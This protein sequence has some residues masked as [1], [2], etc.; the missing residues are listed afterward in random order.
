MS[1]G[2]DGGQWRPPMPIV[3]PR[4]SRR[5]R[6]AAW[7]APRVTWLSVVVSLVWCL[8]VAVALSSALESLRTDDFD[9]LNNMF[10]LPFAFPWALL[11][12]GGFWSNEADSWLLAALG[13]LNGLAILI[14]LDGWIARLRHRQR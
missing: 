12:I 8:M 3:E 2:Q 13:W 4:A 10:Q 1:D 9:G 7:F 11:P 6:I 5:E 14:F